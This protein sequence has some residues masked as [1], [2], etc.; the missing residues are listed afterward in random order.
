MNKL[1]RFGLFM[2]LLARSRAKAQSPFDGFWL[3]DLTRAPLS[4]D[5]REPLKG[6]K[7]VPL[8]AARNSSIG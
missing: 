2:V 7:F 6:K 3:R 1:F 4:R 8:L 5:L